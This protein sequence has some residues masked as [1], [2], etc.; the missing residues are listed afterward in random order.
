MKNL[1]FLAI[2]C[3]FKHNFRRKSTLSKLRELHIKRSGILCTFQKRII[4]YRKNQHIKR[5]WCS[6]W[7][8]WRHQILAVS[9][10]YHSRYITYQCKFNSH[11]PLHLQSSVHKKPD[12]KHLHRLLRPFSELHE[13]LISCLE[14]TVASG[15]SEPR[16]KLLRKKVYETFLI[17]FGDFFTFFF[18][19]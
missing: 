18:T 3:S 8:V 12:F 6:K 19:F 7:A 15:K 17:F 2:C 16:G 13:Y 5:Y 9:E 4:S 11:F 1:H 10:F 14:V